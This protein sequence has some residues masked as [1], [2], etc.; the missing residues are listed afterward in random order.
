MRHQHDLLSNPRTN[1]AA[2]QSNQRELP[3]SVYKLYNITGLEGLLVTVDQWTAVPRNTI[4]T[5]AIDDQPADVTIA[6]RPHF[7]ELPVLQLTT[8]A[9]VT[10]KYDSTLT[11]QKLL[12]EQRDTLQR[13]SLHPLIHMISPCCGTRNTHYCTSLLGLSLNYTVLLTM[14]TTFRCWESWT[15]RWQAR[16]PC[17]VLSPHIGR[18]IIN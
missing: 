4:T 14:R 5:A 11:H 13:I 16:T 10:A 12:R 18:F 15:I 17:R 6:A 3:G 9:A 7:K 8:T 1:F 2:W